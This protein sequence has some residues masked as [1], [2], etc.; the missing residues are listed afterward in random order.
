MPLTLWPRWTVE[1]PGNLGCPSK[2]LSILR[3]LRE[4]Q[5]SQVKHIGSPSGSFPISNGVKQGY[6]LAPTLSSIFFSIVFCEAKEDLP[7]SIYIRFPTYGNVFNHRC[8]LARTK[9]IK[10]LITELLF[11]DDCALL[12]YV[13][14][15]PQHV[16]RLSDA[17]K[18]KKSSSANSKKESVIMAQKPSEETSLHSREST[19]SHGSRRPQTETPGA[20]Q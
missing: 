10:E 13:E 19:I 11:A 4:G 5:K 6:V 20:H 15:A 12:A 8:L 3:Q 1:N 7:D 16:K 18:N 2:F 14:E 9:T 17:A